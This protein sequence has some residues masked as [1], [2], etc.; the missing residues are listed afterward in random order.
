MRPHRCQLREML[1]HSSVNKTDI[2]PPYQ[3]FSYF[4]VRVA[5]HMKDSSVN[6]TDTPPSCLVFSY[7]MVRVATYMKDYRSLLMLLNRSASP[8]TAMTI[9]PL[10]ISVAKGAPKA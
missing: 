7:L 10:A 4:M 2:P 3:V 9:T 8:A 6:K 1:L 5:T